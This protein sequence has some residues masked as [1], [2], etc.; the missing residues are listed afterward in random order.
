M[1]ANSGSH[2]VIGSESAILPSS[3][4]ISA[5]TEVIGLVI[6]AMRKSVSRCIGAPVSRLR[7]PMTLNWISSPLRQTSVT[8]PDRSPSTTTPSSIIGIAA[9]FSAENPFALVCLSM[10]TAFQC[11][12]GRSWPRSRARV[13]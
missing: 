7:L 5:A 3:T 12:A 10:V 4:S 13:N 6:E 11:F 1:L 8:A 2:L 9:S